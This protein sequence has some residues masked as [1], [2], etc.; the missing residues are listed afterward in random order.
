[1]IVRIDQRGRRQQAARGRRRGRSDRG[2]A[3]I[4]N[5]EI[6]K[7][8]R[9]IAVG[10]QK[11][12]AGETVDHRVRFLRSILSRSV[13]TILRLA[14]AQRHLVQEPERRGARDLRAK[15]QR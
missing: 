4:P 2:N 7:R 11:D 14:R 15:G 10:R 5:Q 9:R 3:S 13:L 6:D 1:V 8:T 12:D